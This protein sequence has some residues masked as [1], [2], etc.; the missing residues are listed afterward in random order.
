MS[1]LSSKDQAEVSQKHVHEMSPSFTLREQLQALLWVS[2]KEISVG[3]TYLRCVRAS[4]VPWWGPRARTLLLICVPGGG[5]SPSSWSCQSGPNP[6]SCAK[7]KDLQCLQSWGATLQS[8]PWPGPLEPT[9]GVPD[10]GEASCSGCKREKRAASSLD[11]GQDRWPARQVE[12][13]LERAW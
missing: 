9:E 3:H 13:E 7:K 1:V 8:W 6:A 12:E 2:D 11:P 10:P 5:L 4:L